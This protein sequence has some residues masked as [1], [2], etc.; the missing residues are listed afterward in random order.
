MVL[1][2]FGNVAKH[3]DAERVHANRAS[4]PAGIARLRARLNHGSP[5]NF[6]IF[7]RI[8]ELRL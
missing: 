1:A 4:T 5:A 2:R 8:V 3:A 6:C 7:I